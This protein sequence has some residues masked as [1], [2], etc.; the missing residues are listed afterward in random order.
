MR[1]PV[2]ALPLLFLLASP[3]RAAPLSDVWVYVSGAPAGESPGLWRVAAETGSPQLI[4]AGDF[5]DFDLSRDARTAYVIESGALHA[6]DIASGTIRPLSSG[7]VLS[8]PA[9][10]AVRGDGRIYVVDG[11][12]GGPWSVLVID[13]ETGAQSSLTAGGIRARHWLPG[14]AVDLVRDAT[15]TS[16]GDLLV[17]G[18]V[19]LD[20]EL[21][22]IDLDTGDSSLL[23]LNPDYQG[24]TGLGSDASG[25]AYA[26]YGQTS[27]SQIFSIVGS[28]AS[29]EI[30]SVDGI[31]ASGSFATFANDIDA[32]DLGTVFLTARCCGPGGEPGFDANGLYLL[33]AVSDL[34]RPTGPPIVVGRFSE[35]KA[36]SSVPEP[37][38]ALLLTAAAF[39]L[40]RAARTR[41]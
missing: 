7:G 27:G 4:A 9:E 24:V 28:G 17:A 39:L 36:L 35:V 29:T 11:E 22:R 23:F 18:S 21:L 34:L 12:L 20:D 5:E 19:Q 3:V 25:R 6:V 26:A 30:G 40:A 32:L 8:H 1:L 14:G 15:F 16:D 31:T 33:S 41:T 37:R 13:A 38:S 10:I 2:A